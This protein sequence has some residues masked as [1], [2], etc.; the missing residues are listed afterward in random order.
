MVLPCRARGGD[1]TWAAARPTLHLTVGLPGVG[2]TRPACRIATEQAI[3]G[4]TPE[5]WMAPLSL[6]SDAERRP[7]LERQMIWVAA[8]DVGT[9]GW[10][11]NSD[12][13]PTGP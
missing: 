9:A 13:T 12:T 4:G 2:T 1:D 11:V 10:R 5:E 7:I 3:L 8:R 6:D